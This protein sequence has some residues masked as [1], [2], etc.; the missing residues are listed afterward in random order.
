MD[1]SRAAVRGAVNAALARRRGASAASTASVIR[2]VRAAVGYEL[3]D[4][5]IVAMIVNVAAHYGLG[6]VFDHRQIDV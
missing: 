1:G 6:I 3:A 4:D 5:E 2:E